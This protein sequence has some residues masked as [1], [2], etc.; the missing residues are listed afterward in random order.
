MAE[1]LHLYVDEAGDPALFNSAGK[2]LPGSNGCSSYFILGKIEVDKPDELA[3]ALTSL[4]QELLA[5]SYFAGVESFKPERGKT[6]HLFHAKD[7]LPEVRYKVFELLRKAGDG[8]RFYAVVKDKLVLIKEETAKREVSPGYRYNG[9]HLYDALVRSLFSKFHRIADEYKL[10]VAKRGK[11]DRN[12]A[13]KTALQ[14]AE[15]D[16]ET[17]FGFPRGGSWD[18]TISNPEVTVCLQAV[19]YFLWALQ[20][21]Y[22]VRLDSNGMPL[23]HEDRYI[24]MLWPQ[25]GEIHDL[26]FGGKT[27]TYFTAQKP[28]DAAARFPIEAKKRL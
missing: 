21:F 1:T 17:R 5:D 10:S 6:A 11:S 20:R 19:D 13:I 8:L 14:H 4:R 25:I 26:D 15:K 28:I 23:P 3:A 16:F 12:Q 9:D 7:D 18:I 27:G 22:E 2:V 24:Q